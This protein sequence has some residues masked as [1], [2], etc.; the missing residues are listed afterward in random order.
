V[1]DGLS[2][3]RLRLLEYAEKRLGAAELAKRL[4]TRE[5]NIAAWKRGGSSIP[6]TKLLALAD[7]IDELDR[8]D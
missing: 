5:E 6:N 2:P 7:L 1:Q 4:K 8:R 3:T